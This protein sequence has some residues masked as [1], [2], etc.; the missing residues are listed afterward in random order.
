LP[1]WVCEYYTLYGYINA[2]SDISE[3]VTI[4]KHARDRRSGKHCPVWAW[5]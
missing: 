3:Y 2:L 1:K 4:N 5:Q